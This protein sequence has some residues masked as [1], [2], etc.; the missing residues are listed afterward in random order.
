MGN[1]RRIWWARP[2]KLCALD[3]PGGG[4]RT[5]RAEA[6]AADIAHL[7]ASGVRM[8]VSTMR[9]RHNLADYERA[10]LAWHH[11]PVASCADG[12][13]ALEE[14][15]SL[16]RRELRGRGAIAVHGD[17]H[18]D[19]AAAVCAAHLHEACGVHPADGLAAAAAAGLEATPES[20]RLLGVDH[21]DVMV[22]SGAPRRP[23]PDTPPAEVDAPTLA[24]TTA[25][26]LS[27]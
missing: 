11:V 14:L 25:P 19:F 18:T 2:G 3:R 22:V 5:H 21:G 6:R 8:V 15:L 17:L 4:G 16:L 26:G 20:A 27:G 12:E 1:P 9:T 24:A 23:G 10:G 7:R 13:H